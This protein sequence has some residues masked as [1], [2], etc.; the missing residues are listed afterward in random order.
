MDIQVRGLHKHFGSFHAIRGVSFDIQKGKLVGFLGPSGGGKTSI[1][2]MIAGLENPSSGDIYLG[3]QLANHVPVQK[4][5]IGFVFQHYA[6]FKHMS[7][8]DNVAYGLKVQKKSR[9]EIDERVTYLLKLVGLS[10][11]EKKYPHQLSGGQKQ[12]VAFAR[13]L[14]PQPELLLLDE[15]FAAIDAKIRKEL[16][17]WLRE[18]IN[19]IGITSIFVTHDQDEAIEVADEILVIQQGLLEQQGTPYEVYSKPQSAFVARFIGESNSLPEAPAW[20]PFP[21]LQHYA[22]QGRW[23]RGTSVYIRPEAIEVRRADT[24]AVRSAGIQGEVRHVH[25]RGTAWYL[26]VEVEGARLMAYQ[27]IGQQVFQVGDKVNVLIHRLLVFAPE[28]NT[29]LDNR[30]LNDP[31]PVYI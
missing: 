9:E 28:E 3:G 6:L 29:V 19:E 15:P 4:R 12:R 24:E 20:K 7:V 11:T 25:F 22:E 21:E 23:K 10:G 27:D 31:M 17:S 18:L 1:L 26:E 16:R 2:R 8:Y 30:L 14:A 5:K 13:A